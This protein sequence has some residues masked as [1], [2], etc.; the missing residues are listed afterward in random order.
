MR[1]PRK[2]QDAGTTAAPRQA[3]RGRRAHAGPPAYEPPERAPET[4]SGSA[5]PP[6]PDHAASLPGAAPH[7]TAPPR[8]RGLRPRTVRA[9]IVSLLM[10]P[11]VSLLA[12][13]GFATVT[14]AQDIARLRQLQQVDSEIREPVAAAVTALQAERRAAVRQV[15]SPGAGRATELKDQARRTDAAVA[16]L[17]LDDRNTVGGTGDLPRD[18]SERVDRF[19]TKAEGLGPLRTAA[20]AGKADWDEVYQEYTATITAAF[21]VGGALAGIQDAEVGAHARVLLEFGRVGEML[22]REDALLGSA[23][24]GGELSAERLRL[25]TG[26]VDTRRTLTESATVDLRGPERAA[27]EKLADQRGYQQL[28]SAE[29]R[30]AA[31]GPG[32]K[33][34]QAVSAA[35]W[36]D[37]MAVVRGGLA[38]IESDARRAAADRADPFGGGIFSAGGAAVLLG[39]AAVA[40]SLVISVRIGRGLV[41]ELISLRN[42]ALGIARRKLPSA[43]RRLRAG[44]EIDVR[45][46]APPGPAPQDEIGQVGEA[47]TTVHRAALS[48]AVERAELASGISGVFVNLAR[49]S[50]VLVH[51]QL[52]LLDSMERRADD[53]GELGDLFRLDHLTTRMRRHAES[54]II[55]SGA[56]PG[57]AWRTPVPLTSVVRAA[58]SEIED[59]A[60]VEVRQLAETSVVGGA[61]A[62]LTHLLAELIENAAQFSPPHTKVRISGEPVGNGYA[63]EI[64][65]RGLGMGK[66]S[67]AEANT[68]IAQSEALDLF[69]SDRLGL[70]VVSRL[71]SRHDIKVH[72]RT[73]PYGGTTAVVLLPIDVLQSAL[74]PGKGAPTGRTASA[75]AAFRDGPHGHSVHRERPADGDAS[76]PRHHPQQPVSAASAPAQSQLPASQL[77]APGSPSQPMPRP[78]RIPALAGQSEGAQ[79]GPPDQPPAGVTSLR[80][81]SRP[82][83]QGQSH[84]PQDPQDPQDLTV[85]GQPGAP[86]DATGDLPRRVRQA[87]LV[88]QLREAPPADLPPTPAVQGAEERTPEQVRDRMTAYRDGWTRGGGAA[89]GTRR[90]LG[91]GSGRDFGNATGHGHGPDHGPDFGSDIGRDFG[92]EG[93]HA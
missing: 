19:V 35:T 51:R 64:E 90:P 11:V 73:S 54:L 49:R 23:Y 92:N 67:L 28:T 12:L 43:M 42:T 6:A 29:D 74:P 10:V 48:A 71:S 56:A 5:V 59:Y 36:D 18:V 33:A 27:W 41:I 57:R 83:A 16:R 44:E 91:T 26:A 60:R 22:A 77:P 58:V 65:D 13:W 68:R 81:R 47:L 40:A 8:R 32:R 69:D 20:A 55:L 93:D 85:P 78:P 66:E 75:D 21:A 76:F 24:L 4:P 61:V 70:F 82:A 52:N 63:L 50:Q 30:I 34:L 62:D 2:T 86:A 53:P 84:E 79:Q 89:P 1:T 15:A 25:F 31:A 7:S 9:K 39:L 80:P 45:A 17:R 72:L 88:P 14:T 87:S 3:A 46:E 37:A 38:T